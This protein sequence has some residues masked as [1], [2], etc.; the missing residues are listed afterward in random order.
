M[1]YGLAGIATVAGA[2][3]MS[4]AGG[5]AGVVAIIYA[6]GAVGTTVVRP[7]AGTVAE[8]VAGI[9]VRLVLGS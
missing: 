4:V 1:Y 6:L 3:V 2:V 7:T 5:A 9:A 8:A